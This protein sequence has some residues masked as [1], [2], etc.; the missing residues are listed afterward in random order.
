M[1]ALDEQVG[2][3][4]YKDFEIQPVEF[5]HR[6]GIDFLSGNIIKYVCRWKAKGGL[7]DLEK[8]K[9]YVE[10]LIELSTNKTEETDTKYSCYCNMLAAHSIE[11]C[12]C[13]CHEETKDLDK[14]DRPSTVSEDIL[15]M[16]QQL[17]L[18]FERL[19]SLEKN[20]E[21]LKK[22]ISEPNENEIYRSIERVQFSNFIED[23]RSRVSDLENRLNQVNCN[24]QVKEIKESIDKI[25]HK[26]EPTDTERLDFI[27]KKTVNIT[28]PDYDD[29]EWNVYS[30]PWKGSG[31][32][33]FA[34][35]LRQAIDAA[36][37]G[38]DGE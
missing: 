4:H 28:T 9:H 27:E 10:L 35:T 6:N 24:T 8:A 29:E 15:S 22:H 26:K 20:Q 23:L 12:N 32:D 1:T 13:Q 17:L 11:Y 2:G 5:I 21:E 31:T 25:L 33:K 3:S 30:N 34:T 37:G 14:K 7:Q 18:A 19:G 38:K 16:N 36:M